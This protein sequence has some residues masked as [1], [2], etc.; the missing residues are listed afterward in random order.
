MTPN[1]PPALLSEE[2]LKEIR[3]EASFGRGLHQRKIDDLLIHEAAQAAR[4]EELEKAV[5]IEKI[6]TDAYRHGGRL[7]VMSLLGKLSLQE[8]RITELEA[9]V[10]QLPVMGDGSPAW[11]D[12]IVWVKGRG[13]HTI[14]GMFR[15][16]E[17]GGYNGEWMFTLEDSGVNALA[18]ECSTPHPPGS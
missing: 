18:S 17:D 9:I 8:K 7:N 14:K 5:E 1:P 2:R 12:K 4:I 11:V 3:Y 6:N 10:N 16:T 13:S 15:T